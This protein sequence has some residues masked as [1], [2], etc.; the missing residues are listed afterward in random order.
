MVNIETNK[1]LV[2]AKAFRIA[3][4]MQELLIVK[5]KYFVKFW[6]Y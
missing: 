5:R 1:C 2:Y 6:H 3:Y 4:E